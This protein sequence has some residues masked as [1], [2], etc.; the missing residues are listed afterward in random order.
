MSLAAIESSEISYLQTL[1][2]WS[3][4]VNSLKGWF[5]NP[6]IEA[7]EVSLS[8][9]ISHY[10]KLDDP[11]WL[12]VLGPPGTG[13]SSTIMGS[14]SSLHETYVLD[15]L[16]PTTLLS[17][18]GGSPNK[19]G[20]RK[21]DCS[22][23]NNIGIEGDR[24][25]ILLMPDFTCF[26][27]KRLEERQAIAGQLRKVYDGEFKRMTGMGEWLSW[28]GKVTMI[29]C[30]TPA[31][32]S[33]WALM[34][35]LGERF[36]QVRWA[37][38]DGI[39]QAVVASAQIGSERIIKSG[40]RRLTQA[41][42]DASTLKPI[43]TNPQMIENGVVYL[44]EIIARTRG[45]VKRER[46]GR[47]IIEVPEPE[48]PTR[49]MKALAQ[50]ARSHATLFRREHVTDDDFRISKRLGMD[51]IPPLRRKILETI[52]NY[53]DGEIGHANL[54]RF[55]GAP[56]STVNRAAEDLGALGIL[57]VDSGGG[58]E[59]LYKFSKGFGEIWEKAIPILRL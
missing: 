56:A 44:A 25:G 13:K 12:M 59:K 30:G 28:D 21:H 19:E 48:G 35:D 53:P 6:D 54:V 10:F 46:D 1:D 43:L 23:L 9:A 37:R 49:I 4:L 33:A 24:S 8:V 22:L 52:S 55:V 16:T 42:V 45:H 50:V 36:M 15:D 47:D 58:I 51:S 57:D 3:E 26:M 29:V 5:H 7:L 40:L 27:A 41:F 38:G 11:V 39:Q 20:K 31:V 32:E 18:W 34:R 17:G 2:R 14:L